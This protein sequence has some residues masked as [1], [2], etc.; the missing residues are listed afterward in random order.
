[1]TAAPANIIATA[2][3]AFVLRVRAHLQV[4]AS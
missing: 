2:P 3:D 4:I 1:M